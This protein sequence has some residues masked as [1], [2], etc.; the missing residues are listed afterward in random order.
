MLYYT[1]KHIYIFHILYNMYMYVYIYLSNYLSIYLSLS[2]YIYTYIYIYIYTYIYIYV[3]MYYVCMHIYIY[4]Y[5]HIHTYIYIYIGCARVSTLGGGASH[6]VFR[7][8]AS[9]TLPL[10]QSHKFAHD[11]PKPSWVH[12]KV[13][14]S[15]GRPEAETSTL[16][17]QRSS[18]I[19]SSSSPFFF[20]LPF[21]RAPWVALL[22]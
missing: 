15:W 3:Y 11:A 14:L 9:T 1:H 21:G 13:H 10:L 22:V 12:I 16:A 20:P 7:V 6:N 18:M 8:L 19:T 5:I 2:V 17:R 4:M